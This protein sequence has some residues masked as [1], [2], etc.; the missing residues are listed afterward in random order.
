M[1]RKPWKHWLSG[2]FIFPYDA[3]MM[4]R[5]QRFQGFCEFGLFVGVQM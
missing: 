4:L 3:D 2:T 1:P 5:L